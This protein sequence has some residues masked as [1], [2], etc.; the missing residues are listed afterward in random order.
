MDTT[1]LNADDN[2]LSSPEAKASRLRRLRNLAN[3]TRQQL[4]ENNININTYIGWEYARF[5][6]LTKKGAKKV[7]DRIAQE[8]VVCSIDWLLEGV[9]LPPF[10]SS[11]HTGSISNL[12][13]TDMVLE[14]LTLFSSHYKNIAYLAVP[15]KGML[16]HYNMGDFVA[17]IK[18]QTSDIEQCIGHDCILQTTDYKI[19]FRRLQKGIVKDK[20]SLICINIQSSLHT[21]NIYDVDLQF[22]APIIWHRR[23]KIIFSDEET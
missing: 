7:I 21:Q 10:W 13:E 4:C 20:F 11:C 23:Q 16:P 22:A 6:G 19:L 3:L 18:Y 5:G 17:G 8:N 15:D 9:G 12:S 1:I 2:S 14:E